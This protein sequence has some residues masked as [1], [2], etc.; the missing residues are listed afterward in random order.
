MLAKKRCAS[1][2]ARNVAFIQD[3]HT[4][5]FGCEDLLGRHRAVYQRRMHGFHIQMQQEPEE[6]NALCCHLSNSL[7][8]NEI[9][10]L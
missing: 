1:P 6:D 10:M 8:N 5:L 7:P 2:T 3:M 9:I 4:S